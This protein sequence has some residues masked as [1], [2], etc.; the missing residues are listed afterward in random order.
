MQ[1]GHIRRGMHSDCRTNLNGN[2]FI[3]PVSTP[4][5]ASSTITRTPIT[6]QQTMM[7]YARTSYRYTTVCFN[8]SDG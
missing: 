4:L 5:S 2:H 7:N 3:T 8:S 1:V 6:P